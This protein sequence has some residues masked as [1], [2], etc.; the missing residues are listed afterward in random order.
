MANAFKIATKSSVSNAGTGS[1][2]TNVLT[3]GGSATLVLLSCL[4]SN[5]TA[6]S[7]TVDVF[8]VTN[9][10]DDVFLIKNAPVPAGSSLEI[11]SGSKIIMESSDVLQVRSG[12]AS[13]LDVAVSY[14]E[15]T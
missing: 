9:S 1:T 7:A 14:L 5:K 2:S 15:Q 10:G 6:T 3:A 4:I 8:L 11:I 13:A 12:T